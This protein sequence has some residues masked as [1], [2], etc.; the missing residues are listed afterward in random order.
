MFFDVSK[1]LGGSLIFT[2]LTSRVILNVHD[3]PICFTSEKKY[4][5]MV[6]VILSLV[7]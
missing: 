2:A 1:V 5:K 6:K 4:S 3:T 7:H